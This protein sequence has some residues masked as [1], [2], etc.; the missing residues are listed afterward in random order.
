MALQR[1]ALSRNSR[2]ESL[3]AFEQLA[4]YLT[5]LQDGLELP[6]VALSAFSRTHASHASVER[7]DGRFVPLPVQPVPPYAVVHQM[8]ELI[9]DEPTEVLMRCSEA[10]NLPEELRSI[11]ASEVPFPPLPHFACT[12]QRQGPGARMQAQ[13]D[14]V[15]PQ[16]HPSFTSPHQVSHKLVVLTPSIE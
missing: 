4:A 13:K 7:R 3:P 12:V 8:A 11:A 1:R 5:S 16:E 10:D 14:M 2:S 9:S 6:Y 15:M